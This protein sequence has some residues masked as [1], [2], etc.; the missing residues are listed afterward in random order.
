MFSTKN[1]NNYNL[2]ITD[3]SFKRNNYY[4]HIISGIIPK[5]ITSKIFYSNK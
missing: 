5:N 2:D 3:I 1:I 4:R